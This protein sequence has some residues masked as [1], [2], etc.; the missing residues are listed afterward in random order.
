[1]GCLGVLPSAM[2][3]I[4]VSHSIVQTIRSGLKQQIVVVC[5]RWLV[6]TS[7]RRDLALNTTDSRTWAEENSKSCTPRGATIPVEVLFVDAMI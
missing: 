1:M 4:L 3:I 7:K 6:E 2:S 5:W